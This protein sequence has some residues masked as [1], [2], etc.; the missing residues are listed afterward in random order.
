MEPKLRSEEFLKN[1]KWQCIKCGNC[2]RFV[3]PLAKKNLIPQSW[4]NP[5]GSCLNLDK[6]TNEC[7]IYLVRPKICRIDKAK[8][9]DKELAKMCEVMS[10]V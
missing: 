1:N 8:Y 4:L 10:A 2:C 9:G 5:D 3:E 7:K 6:E